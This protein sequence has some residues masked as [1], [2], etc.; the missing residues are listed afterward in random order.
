MICLI[1]IQRHEWCGQIKHYVEVSMPV[2]TWQKYR[3]EKELG[4]L[5]GVQISNLVHHADPDVAAY[6]PTV[7]DKTNAKAGIKT[8]K[9]TYYKDRY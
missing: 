1:S 3:K 9:L 4:H 5:Y 2:K 8:I 6:C 7:D